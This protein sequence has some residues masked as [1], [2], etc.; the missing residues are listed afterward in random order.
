MVRN[1]G[2]KKKIEKK[3]DDVVDM[4]FRAN[5]GIGGS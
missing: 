1:F 4:T 5:A 2:E 3:E